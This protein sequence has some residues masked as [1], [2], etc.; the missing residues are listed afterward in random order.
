MSKRLPVPEPKVCWC[1]DGY[2]LTGNDYVELKPIIPG[3]L[4]ENIIQQDWSG[5]DLN[6]ESQGFEPKKADS[7]QYKVLSDLKE[8]DYD[9]IYD[10]DC[11]GEILI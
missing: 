4:K 1:V 11:R 2:S 9:I 3:Y 6:K 7:I 8:A 5:I 10:D